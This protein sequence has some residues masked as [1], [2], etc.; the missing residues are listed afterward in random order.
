MAGGL[1]LYARRFATREVWRIEP[2]GQVTR[3]VTGLVFGATYVPFEAVGKA[4]TTVGTRAALD[5]G[6][7][8][9]S[10]HEQPLAY[11]TLLRSA[12]DRAVIPGVDPKASDLATALRGL[13][14]CRKL[15]DVIAGA[16]GTGLPSLYAAACDI[17]LV[18]AADRFYAKLA[19][20]DDPALALELAGRARAVDADHDGNMDAIMDGAWTGTIAGAPIGGATFATV[21]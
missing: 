6:E 5:A 16:L 12:L 15:G 9:I 13:V 4:D 21:K 1:E 10:E 7:L 19:A 3:V 18:E 14:D 17:A 2:S 8:A 11:G 20:L